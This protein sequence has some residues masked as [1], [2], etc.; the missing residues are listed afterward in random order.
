ASASATWS[1]APAGSPG[2][3]E[4]APVGHATL[5]E[6]ELDW[7]GW[8]AVLERAAASGVPLDV[9]LVLPLEDPE[10]RV[11][12]AVAALADVPLARIAAFQPPTHDA[13]HLADEA[14]LRILR[15]ALAGRDVPVVGG[16]R[17]HFTELNRGQHLLAEGAD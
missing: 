12:E 17:S 16:T 11:H 9:R 13:E 2:A 5:V 1:V 15:E 14:A 6:V 10:E 4:T 3:G 7:D 8:P